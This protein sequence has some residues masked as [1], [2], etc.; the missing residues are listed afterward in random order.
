MGDLF[1]GRVGVVFAI[2][3][4]ALFFGAF[5]FGIFVRNIIWVV[6]FLAF[7]VIYFW[8]FKR[9]GVS[10]YL[11]SSIIFWLAAAFGLFN[12]FV[13]AVPWRTI[14]LVTIILY[15]LSGPIAALFKSFGSKGV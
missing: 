11:V 9:T 14:W 15:V 3:A 4:V 12:V 13:E 10:K 6:F 7:G 8:N 2:L 1:D 5:H